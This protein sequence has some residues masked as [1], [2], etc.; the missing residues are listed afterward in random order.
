MEEVEG[1]GE[2][3]TWFGCDVVGGGEVAAN[4]SNGCAW[5]DSPLEGGGIREGSK[6]EGGK[7]AAIF[8]SK[9]INQR[10]RDV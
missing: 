3:V 10:I 2:S 4:E 9:R 1:G 8:L 7:S 6:F 5:G